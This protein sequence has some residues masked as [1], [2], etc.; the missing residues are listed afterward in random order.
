MYQP[1][2]DPHPIPAF[3]AQFSPPAPATQPLTGNLRSRVAVI[4][5]GFTG[6]STALHL[7][8][9]G[10]DSVVLEARS[11]GWGASSR[12]FG[13]IV[14]Y[15]KHDQDQVIRRFG[16]ERGE[17]MINAAARGPDLVF[18][19]IERHGIA[20]NAERKGLIFGAHSLAGR[21]QLERRSEFWRVRGA[22]V[23][24]FEGEAAA[25]LIGS[26]Y[27]EVCA[28]DRRGGT[29]NPLAYVRGLASAAMRAGAKICTET[30]VLGLERRSSDWCVVTPRGEVA[31]DTVVLASNAY[32]SAQLWPGLR[33]S[34]IPMRAYQFVSRPLSDNLRRSVLPQGQP[35]TD[36]RH[37]FSGVRLHPDGR[38]QASADGPAFRVGG[39]GKQ[40]QT[41]RRIA[42]TFPQLGSLEWEFAWAGWVAMTYDQYPHLHRLAPGLWAGLGYSGRGIALAT[43]MGREIAN[44][45]AGA[46][47]AILSLPVTPLRPREMTRFARPMVGALLT[48]YRYLDARHS[49]RRRHQFRRNDSRTIAAK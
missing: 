19:L 49:A 1:S 24:L 43:M 29:I 26:R 42:E 41:T 22:P 34:I 30:A 15:F 20:C 8:E 6:I 31:A 46:D 38:L 48:Y 14:P 45:I 5:G 23:E 2:D 37:L 7:A 27:Y 40:A 28:L 12:N 47:E 9:H 36:T 33:Q 35:L 16:I 39:S 18:S 10:I 25:A 32:T 17:Q 4:G 3:Y 11:I 21:V 13:Q 44:L